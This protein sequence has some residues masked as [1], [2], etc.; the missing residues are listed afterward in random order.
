MY[1]W[2]YFLGK[3]HYILPSPD[4]WPAVK[5]AEG[6]Y[7]GNS[8]FRNAIFTES[9]SLKAAHD[10]NS[11]SSRG[12]T[13]VLTIAIG[14]APIY[15]PHQFQCKN[16]HARDISEYD[17]SQHFADAIEFIEEGRSRGGILVHWYDSN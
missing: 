14:V 3:I 16:Y 17:I 10:H 6:L 13:H 15:S 8:N 2:G 12:I 9:G 1:A 11:L 7:L 5:I 4:P